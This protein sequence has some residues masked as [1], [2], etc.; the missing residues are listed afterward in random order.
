MKK[1]KFLLLGSV[2]LSLI[3]FVHKCSNKKKIK[4]KKTS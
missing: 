4:K 2:A 1:S 3:P